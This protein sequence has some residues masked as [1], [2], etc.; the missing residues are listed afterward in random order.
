MG[1]SGRRKGRRRELYQF[2]ENGVSKL[3]PEISYGSHG[4]IS[5]R[6]ASE[7]ANTRRVVQ[8]LPEGVNN[9]KLKIPTELSE[10]V[11]LWPTIS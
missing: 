11:T 9:R 2:L 8:D 5:V 3:T 6:I 7:F 1:I 4:S 10:R